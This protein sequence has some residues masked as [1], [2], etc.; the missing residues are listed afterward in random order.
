MGRI[1]QVREPDG[2]LSPYR[3]RKIAES[4]RRALSDAGSDDPALADELAGVVS[5][6]L[7]RA[8]P[9]AGQPPRVSDIQDVTERVLRETGH[10]AA[11]R[12]FRKIRAQREEL[13]DQIV[14]RDARHPASGDVAA[15]DGAAGETSRWS[16][17]RLARSLS[18]T[19]EVPGPVAE[20]VASAVER[21]VFALGLKSVTADL[22]RHLVACEMFDRGIETGERAGERVPILIRSLT[23][24]LFAPVAPERAPGESIAAAVLAHVALTDVHSSGVAAAHSEGLLHV[25]GL[26]NPL[27]VERLALPWDLGLPHAP[28]GGPFRELL[29]FR[30]TLEAVRPHVAGAI[31]LPDAASRLLAAAP[32]LADDLVDAVTFRDAYDRAKGPAVEI[33]VPLASV[34]AA[35]MKRLAARVLGGAPGVRL[36]L[37]DPSPPET[38]ADET[39]AAAFELM[40][41]TPLVALDLVREDDLPEP[42]G[43]LRFSLGRVTLNL[44]LLLMNACGEGLK[45]ALSGLDRGA[46]LALEAF[47]ERAWLQ[48]KGPP[49]GLQAI[50]AAVGGPAR[51]VVPA[52]GQ[53]VDL[54]FW[55]LAHALELLVRRGLVTR[56]SVS[57]AA[58][59]ILGH[60]LYH[61]GDERDG[62][63]FAARTGG[64]C[65]TAVRK[66]MLVACESAARRF[67]AADLVAELATGRAPEGLLPLAVPLSDR[68]NGPL[69]RSAAIE[70]LGWGLGLPEAC[71]PGGLSRDSLAAI[72]AGSRFRRFT[73]GPAGSGIPFEVQEELFG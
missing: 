53:E 48:R 7:E 65:E 29:A 20:E 1:H 14:V 24:E 44:P 4:I 46:R 36:V 52:S 69:L 22:V 15:G 50:I 37:R 8:H 18:E 56:S 23:E 10:D 45:E 5:L 55:G 27:A 21:K 12:R 26:E 3:E 16:R 30:R 64:C 63:R 17:S 66:R 72:R 42:P 28:G 54:E 61:L 60:V 13:R 19:L 73:L 6:F 59:R 31:E 71:L 11:A 33:A 39:L 62:I 47:H 9:D 38:C 25:H 32:D 70:R 57:D 40:R 35:A 41:A 68:R 67:A 49:F 58:A 34:P 43:A 2:S 51:V